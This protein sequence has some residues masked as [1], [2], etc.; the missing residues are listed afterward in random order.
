[1]RQ[2]M[3][4]GDGPG[5]ARRWHA[6]RRADPAR[7]RGGRRAAGGGAAGLARVRAPDQQRRPAARRRLGR[8][9]APHGRS[10]H[11][12]PRP[13]GV[14][15]RRRR[16]PA[17]PA[18]DALV[19]PDRVAGQPGGR[20]PLAG[21]HPAGPGVRGGGG[22]D[23]A[24]PGRAAQRRRAAAHGARRG[25]HRGGR[26]RTR[27]AAGPG[28]P[29][30]PP[31]GRP[32][33]SAHPGL[34]ARRH[35][36]PVDRAAAHRRRPAPPRHRTHPLL[37]RHR[38]GQLLRARQRDHHARG[39][40]ARPHGRARA[41]AA[42]LPAARCRDL[43]PAAGA[44]RRAVGS[45]HGA[46]PVPAVPADRAAGRRRR[47]RVAALRRDRLGTGLDGRGCSWW[48]SWRGCC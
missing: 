37:R 43:P 9:P 28:E 12:R 1:M 39:G 3:R 23:A 21:R 13:R 2:P 35:R 42:G 25:A 27:L 31:G 36:D 30:P 26:L 44:A 40:A 10:A 16:D 19:R 18:V 17:V 47:V 24:D 34:P 8:R 41:A 22:R 15:G 11:P 6:D 33:R 29:G 38:R 20:A 4:G 7:V 5:P 48:R 46:G 45:Q 14:G 32:G